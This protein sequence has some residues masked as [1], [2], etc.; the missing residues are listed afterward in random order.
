MSVLLAALADEN[1]LAIVRA[2]S[3]GA[4]TLAELCSLT[5][6]TQFLA[7]RC[8]RVLHD[9]GV[10]ISWSTQSG[11]LHQLSHPSMRKVADIVAA[12]EQDTQSDLNTACEVE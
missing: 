10:V 3:M 9:D 12:M 7:M 1:R 8:L 11:R 4:R 6:Q 5:G 2:L